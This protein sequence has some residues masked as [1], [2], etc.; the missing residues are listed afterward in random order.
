QIL[1]RLVEH[2]APA[3]QRGAARR[4]V[5]RDR[6]AAAAARHGAS[7]RAAVPLAAAVAH[8]HRPQREEVAGVAALRPAR[9]PRSEARS[10][11]CGRWRGAVA[12]MTA[13]A[14]WLAMGGYAAFV[15]PAY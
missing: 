14:E 3:G 5:D 2:A 9:A 1:G 15:W 6:D 4:P 11:D 10:G 13:L 7:V 12:A 8:A